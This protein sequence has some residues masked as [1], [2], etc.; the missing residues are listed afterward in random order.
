M[1]ITHGLTKASVEAAHTSLVASFPAQSVTV[2][3]DGNSATGIKSNVETDPDLEEYGRMSNYKFSV[4]I[5]TDDLP[6]VDVQKLVT[7][8]G[9]DHLV[10]DMVKDHTGA[11]LRLHLGDEHA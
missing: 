6:G 2:S 5:K 7:I 4:R 9:T 10:L 3:Y 1:T 8:S 11:M